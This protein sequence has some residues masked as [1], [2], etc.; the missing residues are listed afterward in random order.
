VTTNFVWRE[1]YTEAMLELNHEELPHRIDAAEKAIYQRLEE[2]KQAPNTDAEEMWA[3]SDA[4][5]G[6]RV[7]A[8]AEC[9]AGRLAETDKPQ[10]GMAS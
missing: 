7:L 3:L 2:V 8:N 9:Q 1:K 5:R 4:L 6:L 10:R